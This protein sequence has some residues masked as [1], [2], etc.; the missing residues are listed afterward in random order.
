MC[1]YLI[2]SQVP[3]NSHFVEDGTGGQ[4]S[5]LD[6]CVFAHQDK[7][8]VFNW[9]KEDFLRHYNVRLVNIINSVKQ[10]E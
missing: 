5:F 3:L 2:Q 1:S 10:F 9:L 8:D 6:Q 4:C 7:E